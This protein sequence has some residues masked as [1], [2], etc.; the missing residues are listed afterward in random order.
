VGP[1]TDRLTVF[2]GADQIVELVRRLVTRP[3]FGEAP[4]RNRDMDKWRRGGPTGFPMV[5]L[6]RDAHER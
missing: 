1:F 5:C 2:D 3:R 4:D 6:V